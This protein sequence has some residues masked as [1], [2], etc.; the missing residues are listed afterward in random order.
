LSGQT[1][2]EKTTVSPGSA[3]TAILKVWS[4]LAVANIDAPVLHHRQ[5]AVFLEDQAPATRSADLRRRRALS[6]VFTGVRK[7]VT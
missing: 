5:G 4:G 2:Q 3:F 6:A 1:I 7:P